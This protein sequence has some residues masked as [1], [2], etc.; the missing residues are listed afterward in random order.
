MSDI[1]PPKGF[2]QVADLEMRNKKDPNFRP[3]II[4]SQISL[5]LKISSG[6][7]RKAFR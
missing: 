1:I 4:N 6:V 3:V 7:H 2:Y 5:P